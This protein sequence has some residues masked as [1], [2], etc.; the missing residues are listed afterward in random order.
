MADTNN[1][2]VITLQQAKQNNLKEYFTGKPCINGHIAHRIVR[3]RSCKLCELEAKSERDK[4]YYKNNREKLLLKMKQNEILYGYCKNWRE[5]NKEKT[6]KLNKDWTA[7]NRKHINQQVKNRRE[8]D[9][10][11]DIKR[12][13]ST[14]ISLVFKHKKHNKKNKSIEIIGCSY[15]YLITHIEKQFVCG[16]TWDNRQLWHIDHIVPVATAKTEDELIKL[17]HFTNLRPI[18]AKDNLSKSDKNIFLI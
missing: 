14:M 2:Q 8:K 13:I 6:S 11:F 17:N 12:R 4:R 15:E 10:L 3:N 5:K 18:W 7:K 16:M 1:I 9:Y